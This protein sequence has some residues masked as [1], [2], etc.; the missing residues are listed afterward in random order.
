MATL[1]TSRINRA[2]QARLGEPV[3]LPSG[4]VVEGIWERTPPPASPWPE[5]GAPLQLPYQ[6]SPAVHLLA[7]D[8][9]GLERNDAL[10]IRGA[11]WLIA[12]VGPD[13]DGLV[14]LPLRPAAITTPTGRWK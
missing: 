1:S 10:T 14:R 11:T 9:A 8:A 4:S 7:S 6:P 13:L 12:E 3:T 5:P 2:M